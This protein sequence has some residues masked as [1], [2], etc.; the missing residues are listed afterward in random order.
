MIEYIKI[1]G[2]YCNKVKNV[3]K[4]SCILVDEYDGIV[5][6]F[7]VVLESLSGVGCKIVNVVLNMWW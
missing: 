5:F 1:I 7:C 2:F 6:N 4:L 3:M